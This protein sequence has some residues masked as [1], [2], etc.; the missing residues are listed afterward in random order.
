MHSVIEGLEL[1]YY[2]ACMHM[3]TDSSHSSDDVASL[4]RWYHVVAY[5]LF[6]W[7]SYH[8]HMCHRIL[9]RI[10]TEKR[11]RRDSEVG[12]GYGQPDGDWFEYVSCPHFLAE[13]LIYVAVLLCFIVTDIWS[14]WWLVIVY[15]LSTLG[16]SARQ[17]HA[18]YL[19]KY[20]D[21]PKNRY[22]IIPWI[23]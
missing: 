6:L 10:R 19:Q 16:L 5:A 1:L 11:E 22:A 14:V 21:Y 18:Y 8:Q 2:L 12:S 15:L 7:A 13:I 23:C 9:A 17:T 4:L 3:H 20:E